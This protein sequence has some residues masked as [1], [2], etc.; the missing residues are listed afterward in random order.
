MILVPSI[1]SQAQE[2]EEEVNEIQI[3]GERTD[4]CVRTHAAVRECHSHVLQALRIPRRKTGKDQDANH[5]NHK[6]QCFTVP[7]ETDD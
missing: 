3:E 1:S 6:L 2:K 4:H 5:R 7:E